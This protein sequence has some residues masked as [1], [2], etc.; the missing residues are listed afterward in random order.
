MDV[1]DGQDRVAGRGWTRTGKES[2]KLEELASLDLLNMTPRQTFYARL[3][4]TTC[5]PAVES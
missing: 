1:S 4:E 2:W 3:G 5:E